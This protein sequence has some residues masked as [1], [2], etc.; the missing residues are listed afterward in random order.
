[1][2]PTYFRNIA[3]KYNN[4]YSNNKLVQETCNIH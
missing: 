1:M 4:D 2:N 3:T